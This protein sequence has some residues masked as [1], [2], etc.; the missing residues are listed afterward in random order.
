M[1]AYIRF[2]AKANILQQPN[3]LLCHSI[4]IFDERS[5][6]YVGGISLTI[7]FGAVKQG[8]ISQI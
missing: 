7:D 6:V 1:E 2:G 5:K 4:S 3:H 8:V